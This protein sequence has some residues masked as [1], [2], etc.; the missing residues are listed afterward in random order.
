MATVQDVIKRLTIVHT[1]PGADEARRKIKSIA[2]AQREVAKASVEIEEGND[3]ERGRDRPLCD[4]R[5]RQC[6][7]DGK[8]RE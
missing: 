4:A 2:D 5:S 6:R 1:A 8:E 7:H 3:V